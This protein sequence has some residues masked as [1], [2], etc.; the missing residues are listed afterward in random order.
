[1][2]SI[3]KIM[4]LLASVSLYGQTLNLTVDW[5]K[6]ILGDLLKTEYKDSLNNYN[7]GKL[8][9]ETENK[10]VYGIIGENYQRIK[11]KILSLARQKKN[12]NVYKVFGKSMVKNRVCDFYGTIS[13]N[14]IKV[15]KVMH[16]GVDD[17]YKNRGIKRQGIL[18]AKYHLKEDSSKTHS[19]EFEGVLFTSWDLDKF[20]KLQ[21]DKI[22]YSSDNYR[23]NQFIGT[24]TEYKTKKKKVSNWADYRVPNCGDLDMGAGE[25]SPADKYLKFGWQA[26]RDTYVN[27]NKK[28]RKEEEKQWWK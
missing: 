22:E 19:G 25:F 26:Y 21:Y 27:D 24:W 17:E 3:I 2:K 13:I 16:W 7:F 10:N 11:I 15:Y 28:A 8:W 1:M 5:Q 4:I 9:T 20:G 18:I 14:S 12:Q 6:H 23:N